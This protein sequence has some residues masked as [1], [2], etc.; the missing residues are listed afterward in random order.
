MLR[1]SAQPA[2]VTRMWWDPLGSETLANGRLCEA[3]LRAAVQTVG[4]ATAGPLP[5]LPSSPVRNVV[6]PWPAISIMIAYKSPAR[7]RFLS[8]RCVAGAQG[9]GVPYEQS[10]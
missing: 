3:W 2:D 5:A 10:E 4:V 6:V 9:S 1:A 7:R 8:P